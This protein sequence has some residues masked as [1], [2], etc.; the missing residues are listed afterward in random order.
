MD[1]TKIECWFYLISIISIGIVLFY[2]LIGVILK[3]RCVFL[4]NKINSLSSEILFDAE[5]KN[6]ILSEFNS[7]NN[8]LNDEFNEKIFKFSLLINKWKNFHYRFKELKS[9]QKVLFRNKDFIALNLRSTINGIPIQ[10]KINDMVID[11][12]NN[13]LCIKYVISS[14]YNDLIKCVDH[15][16]VFLFALFDFYIPNIKY[17]KFKLDKKYFKLKSINFKKINKESLQKINEKI[18]WREDVYYSHLLLTFITFFM[19]IYNN[20]GDYGTYAELYK[21]NYNF[22][23]NDFSMYHIKTKKS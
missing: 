7:K 14:G 17:K 8:G 18:M 20:V 3:W 10:Y 2:N 22:E 13:C 6:K 21:Q 11:E 15:N 16:Y 12:H 4:N 19:M 1:W 5:I 23:K 9:I